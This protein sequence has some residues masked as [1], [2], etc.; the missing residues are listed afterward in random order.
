MG[1]YN[2]KDSFYK[3]AKDEG[4]RSRA[5]YKLEEIDRKH[6]LLKDGMSVLDLGCW[7]GGWLEHSAK[8]VGVR[9][10]VIGI[11]L[12]DTE[13]LPFSNVRTLQGDIA[14]SSTTERA[15]EMNGGQ[16]DVVL[17]DMSPKL[18]GIREV[19][20]AASVGLAEKA[21]YV[22]GSTLRHGGTIVIKVFKGAGTDTFVKTI[23]PMFN[24]LVRMELDSTRKSSNE[25]YLIGLG[26]SGS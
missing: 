15:L 3:R 18:T 13:P 4:H 17:S 2:R 23:R 11:D 22:A 9:G 26:F 1:N 5:V 7:P 21:I 14:D 25:F 24:K 12:V 10:S 6:K 16:F 20:D 19:D 8:R